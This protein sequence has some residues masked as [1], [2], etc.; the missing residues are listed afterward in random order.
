[1]RELLGL[2]PDARVVG[3]I[4][5]LTAEKDYGNL[6]A[7]ATHLV[8][9]R[10]DVVVACV[11]GGPLLE[12]MRERARTGD[13]RGRVHFLGERADAI[14]LAADFDVFVLASRFEGLPVVLMEALALG[15]PIVA[16]DAG[17][18]PEIVVDG[19]TGR[20]VPRRS[21]EKLAGAVL[22]LLSDRE[23]AARFA[24]RA[25]EHSHVFSV[26]R[27]GAGLTRIYDEV[28]PLADSGRSRG[29]PPGGPSA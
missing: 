27:L 17:G 7:A 16:T 24:A 15:L 14:E 25:R 18:V 29:L 20:C 10:R 12:E 21:P 8:E 6:L 11:G 28:C 26:E 13:L 9:A 22:E 5:S 2:P 4:A 1:M 3:T 23:A 19:V